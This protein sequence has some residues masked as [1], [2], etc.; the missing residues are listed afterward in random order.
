MKNRTSDLGIS[1]LSHKTKSKR[2]P[3]GASS[4]Q[5]LQPQSRVFQHC[6]FAVFE[7]GLDAMAIME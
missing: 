2:V 5:Q 6:T 4:G 7:A 3:H 1:G